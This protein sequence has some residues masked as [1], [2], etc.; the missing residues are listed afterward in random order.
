MTEADWRLFLDWSRKWWGIHGWNRFPLSDELWLLQLSS[1]EEVGRVLRLGRW[2]FRDRNIE[3]DRWFPFAGRSRVSVDRGVVWLRVDGIPVHLRSLSL[4]KQ[5]G[6]YCGGFLDSEESG[7]S[8]NSIRVKIRQVGVIP[9]CVPIKRGD[10]FYI[11]QVTVEEQPQFVEGWQGVGSK[12]FVRAGKRI[13]GSGA[14]SVKERDAQTLDKDLGVWAES[15]EGDQRRGQTK[16]KNRLTECG[17][18]TEVRVESDKAVKE[19]V[20]GDLNLQEEGERVVET[21]EE[22]GLGNPKTFTRE[23][24]FME[25]GLAELAG[26]VI[27]GRLEAEKENLDEEICTSTDLCLEGLRGPSPLKVQTRVVLGKEGEDVELEGQELLGLE[28][29]QCCVATFICPSECG[30]VPVRKDEKN[31]SLENQ[32]F[33]L[34]IAE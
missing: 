25:A 34:A 2:G 8:W 18:S 23:E 27:E 15:T 3:A 30:S 7:C 14:D 19:G 13:T 29:A 32:T 1:E 20:G 26:H 12:V 6:E 9:S 31:E 4:F 33:S 5:V 28:E 21:L 24:L 22:E 11:L 17:D 10:E 16:A